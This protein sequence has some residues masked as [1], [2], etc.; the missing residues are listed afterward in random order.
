MGISIEL[1]SGEV[2]SRIV[3]GGSEWQS[4]KQERKSEAEI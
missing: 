2:K 1:T 3:I 4:I